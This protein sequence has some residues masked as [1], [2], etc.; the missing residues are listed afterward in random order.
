MVSWSPICPSVIWIERS[1]PPWLPAP[2]LNNH[3]GIT[4]SEPTATTEGI[5]SQSM[6]SSGGCGKSTATSTDAGTL[7]LSSTS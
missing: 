1:K 7:T 3:R 5:E 4:C 6:E 2:T